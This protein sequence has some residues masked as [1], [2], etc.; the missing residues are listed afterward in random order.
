LLI[1]LAGEHPNLLIPLKGNAAFLLATGRGIKLFENILTLSIVT[2]KL[3]VQRE[4]PPEDYPPASFNPLWSSW[5]RPRRGGEYEEEDYIYLMSEDGHVYYLVFEQDTP[6]EGVVIN[7][8]GSLE[9]HVNSACAPFGRSD[10]GDVLI[11]QGASS[12]GCVWM[13]SDAVKSWVRRR[14][15]RC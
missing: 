13:V 5:V 4:D 11:V 10:Q 8:V 1:R 14:L 2:T 15:I 3:I 9:C 7:H 12:T 6:A